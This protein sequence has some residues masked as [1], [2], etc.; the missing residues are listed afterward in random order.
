MEP[1]IKGSEL[2]TVSQET[3][4]GSPAVHS[5]LHPPV[6]RLPPALFLTSLELVFHHPES[7]PASGSWGLSNSMRFD[8]R[9]SLFSFSGAQAREPSAPHYQVNCTAST[10]GSQ[11]GFDISPTAFPQTKLNLF[12][13]YTR[14]SHQRPGVLCYCPL[15]SPNPVF[16]LFLQLPTSK[17]GC[18]HIQRSTTINY[19][20][21][22][23]Q[24]QE[25]PTLFAR[26]YLSQV[27][28]FYLK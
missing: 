11:S 21:K 25:K 5:C 26:K 18:I 8:I 4:K 1:G 22:M 19:L 3:G 10:S 14:H 13:A 23:P 12:R 28:F 20:R 7:V 6:L 17:Y 2:V 24:P 16:L 9:S 15:Q 27:E